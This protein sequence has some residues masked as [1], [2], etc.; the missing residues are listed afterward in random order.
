MESL[1]KPSLVLIANEDE[2]G[3][4]AESS[5]KFRKYFI[6]KNRG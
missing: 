1:V 6:D 3:I 4:K 5:K 2:R